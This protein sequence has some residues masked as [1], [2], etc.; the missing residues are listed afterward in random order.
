VTDRR[1]R[2]RVSTSAW[3]LG[4]ILVLPVLALIGSLAATPPATPSTA[5]DTTTRSATTP[6]AS[7]ATAIPSMTS[8]TPTTATT[9]SAGTSAGTALALL[10]TVPV[11]G[12]APMT[13]YTRAQFG[14]AWADVDHNGCGTRNDILAR[15]L[16]D[17]TRLR[18]CRVLS[19]VLNDPY[20]GQ[21]IAFVRGE[22]TS[23]RVQIDHVVALGDAWQTGA[24]QLTAEQRLRLA[25]DPTNLLAVS[26]AANDQKGDGDAAT[27]LPPNK[28]FR[29]AYVAR[30]VSVKAAYGLWMTAAEHDAI[31]RLL[32]TCPAQPALVSPL[33]R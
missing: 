32:Q 19:G 6:P 16:V 26:G 10:A 29:C 31:Q 8:R 27:W 5:M 14:P 1:S 22:G 18:Q 13:G 11:K 2:R 7:A 25:N 24:Q 20:T 15:D 9:P 30:Q 28:A 21:R 33:G 17:I 4:V 23:A 12:R 3:V